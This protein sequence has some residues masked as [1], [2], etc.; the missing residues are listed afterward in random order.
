[1]GTD[2]VKL[3]NKTLADQILAMEQNSLTPFLEENIGCYA[4]VFKGDPEGSILNTDLLPDQ[5]EERFSLLVPDSVAQMI[6]SLYEHLD[7][8]RVMS[9][10]EIEEVERW[11]DLCETNRDFMVAYLFDI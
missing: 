11:R 9:R 7:D 10:K 3:F 4:E 5:E 1:M 8:L 6:K 2:S